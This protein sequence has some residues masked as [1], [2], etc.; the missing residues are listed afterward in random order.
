MTI[1]KLGC[2]SSGVCLTILGDELAFT[3]VLNFKQGGVVDDGSSEDAV[4]ICLLSIYDIASRIKYI[5]LRIIVDI[6]Y[7]E[8]S[9]YKIVEL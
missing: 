2:R 1:S 4:I 3:L 7:H 8:V 9:K 5:L 6:E